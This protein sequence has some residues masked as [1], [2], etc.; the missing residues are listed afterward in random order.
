MPRQTDLSGGFNITY[1]PNYTHSERKYMIITHLSKSSF[2]RQ[3]P[4]FEKMNK[5]NSDAHLNFFMHCERYFRLKRERLPILNHEA[6]TIIKNI[7]DPLSKLGVTVEV[8]S[9]DGTF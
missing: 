5:T 1:L 7:W 8:R 2:D 6:P 3:K 9:F 4:E